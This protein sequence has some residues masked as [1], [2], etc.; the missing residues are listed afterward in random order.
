M[1]YKSN[2]I[3]SIESSFKINIRGGLTINVPISAESV[4]P[5]IKVAE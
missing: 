3:K 4:A 5:N 1:T 2:L